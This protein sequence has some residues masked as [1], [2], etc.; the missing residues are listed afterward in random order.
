MIGVAPLENL[1]RDIV[2]YYLFVYLFIKIIRNP[3][4]VNRSDIYL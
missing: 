2:K 1:N 3:L 4:H